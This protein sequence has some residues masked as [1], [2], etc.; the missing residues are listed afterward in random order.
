[1]FFF[2]D[3]WCYNSV[4]NSCRLLLVKNIDT[5][6]HFSTERNSQYYEPEGLKSQAEET[7]ASATGQVTMCG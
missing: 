7:P 3:E 6:Y 2:N 1:M 4:I 5:V